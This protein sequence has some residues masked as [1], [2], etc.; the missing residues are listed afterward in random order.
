MKMPFKNTRRTEKNSSPEFEAVSKSVQEHNENHR[1]QVHDFLNSETRNLLKP[2]VF[3]IR[4]EF[5]NPKVDLFLSE[6]T[7]HVVQHQGLLHQ[8]ESV[9][10]D[11]TEIYEVNLLVGDLPLDQCPVVTELSPNLRNLLGGIDQTIKSKG[12]IKSNHMSIHAGSMLRADGGFLILDAQDILAEPGAWRAL[13]RI[14]RSGRLEIVPPEYT[15]PWVPQRLTP[16]PIEIDVK[17]VLVGDANIYY[18]LNQQDPDFSELFKVLADFDDQIPRTSEGIQQYAQVIRKIEKEEDLVHFH[19]S[20]IARLVEHGARVIA[21]KDKLTARF[22]R[23]ADLARE[24]SYLAKKN[25]KTDVHKEQVKEAIVNTR[26]RASLPSRR[27]HELLQEG[28][29]RLETHGSTVGQINGLAVMTA[30]P[31]TYGFPARITASIGAGSEGLVNVERESLLSGAIHT[32]GFFILEGLLRY[33]LKTDFP[34][35]FSASLAFEQSYGGI[36]GDSASGAEICCLLSAL[37]DIPIR[38]DFALTGAIDQMG[39]ILPIGGANEKIEGFFDCC[40]CRELTGTQGV[41][42]PESNVGDLM[43]REDVVEACEEK[44][45][46]VYGAKNIHEVLELLMDMPAG[47]LDRNKNYPRDSILGKA[48]QKALEF[49]KSSLPKN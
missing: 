12:E 40:R 38:Q 25:G 47:T 19:A 6:L 31:L 33:L 14:L 45:F 46:F 44:K 29:L 21:R 34:L 39:N 37:T 3:S 36:D 18:L 5:N 8:S 49:W 41:I 32:K 23:I 30:G 35:T 24:A 27:Y 7:N 48:Q 16:E 11:F 20:A 28:V 26:Q 9:K 10:A 2:L 13:T 43:L 4:S 17:V 42:I 15:T 22:G 1:K